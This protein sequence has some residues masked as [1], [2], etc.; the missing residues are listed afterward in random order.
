MVT[1][2]GSDDREV[3]GYDAPKLN[4]VVMRGVDEDELADFA[5]FGAER[6]IEVR[7][8]EFMPFR[9]NGWVERRLVPCSE[10]MTRLGEGFGLTE[11]A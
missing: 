10:L 8:I 6:G 11:L 2:G 3:S 4:V 5:R 1:T 7:F 9:S